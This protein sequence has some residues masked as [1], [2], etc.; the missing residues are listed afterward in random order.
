MSK[1]IIIYHR[2]DND[3]VCSAAIIKHYLVTKDLATE[4]D[5]TMFPATYAILTK[6]VED[7]GG[8]EN[9]FSKWDNIIMTDMSFDNGSWMIKLHKLYGGKFTWIDHHAPIIREVDKAN[10]IIN[11]VQRT[12]CSAILN[13]YK[14]CWDVFDTEYLLGNAPKIFVYLSAWDSFSFER[15]CLDRDEVRMVNMAFTEMSEISVDWYYNH[16]TDILNDSDYNDE[17][18]KNAL[19]IGRKIANK[20][21]KTNADLIE[22][23]GIGGFTVGPD[24]RSAIALFLSGP[25]NSLMFSSVADKYKHGVVFKSDNTG[26]IVVSLYDIND[27]H[28]FHCG[29]YLKKTYG[30]GGHEGAAGCTLTVDK[31]TN[32]LKSKHI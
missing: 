6:Y 32:I 22:H 28:E 12:E 14:Y 13:A 17:V 27:S 31:F 18:I 7:N 8:I 26:N 1:Y 29:E 4:E 20:A 3:G 9:A 16:M 10:V 15:E 30:G 24:N 2:D 25:T 5:I 23:N 19:E 21:D 11:G